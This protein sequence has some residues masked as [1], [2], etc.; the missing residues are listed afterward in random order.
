MKLCC[1]CD[2][3]SKNS[4]VLFAKL[5]F[6]AIAIFAIH[7]ITQNQA[8]NNF[9]LLVMNQLTTE[10]NRGPPITSLDNFMQRYSSLL[11]QM[12]YSIFCRAYPQSHPKFDAVFREKVLQT[13]TRW[14]CG[15]QLSPGQ[16]K[17][18]NLIRL[19]PE[20]FRPTGNQN[21]TRDPTKEALVKEVEG[22]DPRTIWFSHRFWCVDPGSKGSREKQERP[23][24]LILKMTK[25]PEKNLDFKPVL[26]NLKMWIEWRWGEEQ[27][28]WDHFWKRRNRKC[29]KMSLIA[30]PVYIISEK[31]NLIWLG[32]RLS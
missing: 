30:L 31:A 19:E 13:C 22:R 5:C 3:H 15:I 27:M 7:F 20:D 26:K 32:Y 14:I 17:K 21:R 4:I 12:I 25:G 16:A 8:S 18:W 29:H 23:S 9:A 6:F 11:A 28:R 2:R 24:V 1:D 10:S